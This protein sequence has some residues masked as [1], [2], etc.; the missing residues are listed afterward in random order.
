MH[1]T[2]NHYLDG[3]CELFK[4]VSVEFNDNMQK[5]EQVLFPFIRFLVQVEKGKVVANCLPGSI[6]KAV[7]AMERRHE[8]IGEYMKHIRILSDDYSLPR[9]SP[10]S[11]SLLYKWL[12]AFE[13]DLQQHVHLENNILFPKAIELEKE[14]HSKSNTFKKE[15]ADQDQLKDRRRDL[16]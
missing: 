9:R 8:A 10:S 6:E 7:M 11:Y 13:D 15:N 1:G 2:Q 5:E 12:K 14:Y 3:V 16:L 4:Q